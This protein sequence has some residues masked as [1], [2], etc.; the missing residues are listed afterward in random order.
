MVE[1]IADSGNTRRRFR[2]RSK[3]SPVAEAD[4]RRKNPCRSHLGPRGHPRAA[5][6]NRALLCGGPGPYRVPSFPSFD[7]YLSDPCGPYSR[8]RL[9]ALANR[10]RSDGPHYDDDLPHTT[11]PIAGGCALAARAQSGAGAGSGAGWGSEPSPHLGRRRELGLRARSG[12]EVKIDGQ[13]HASRWHGCR[14]TAQLLRGSHSFW[15][16]LQIGPSDWAAPVQDAR[17]GSR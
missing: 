2:T 17:R 9:D 13:P 8:C 5:L 1:F 15:P 11:G 3:L 4:L 6:A 16:T 7:S 14:G 10:Y 12:E